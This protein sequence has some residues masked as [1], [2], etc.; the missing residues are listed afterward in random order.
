MTIRW[1]RN[2]G[3]WIILNNIMELSKSE[4]AHE[5]LMNLTNKNKNSSNID[6][7]LVRAYYSTSSDLK[8]YRYVEAHIITW[9]MQK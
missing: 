8:V 5:N 1:A 6:Y 2:S 9:P 3:R 7:A 4:K